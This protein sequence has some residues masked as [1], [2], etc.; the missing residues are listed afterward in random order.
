[1]NNIRMHIPTDTYLKEGLMDQAS[2]MS[3]PYKKAL[4]VTTKS[5]HKGRFGAF[6]KMKT[7]LEKEGLEVAVFD[8]ITRPLTHKS[9]LNGARIAKEEDVDLIVG[10]GGAKVIDAAKVIGR[11]ALENPIYLDAWLSSKYRPPF[12]NTPIDVIAV[13]TTLT[14]KA[15]LNHKIYLYNPKGNRYERLKD[16]SFTPKAA[17]IDPIVFH[18]LDEETLDGTLSDALI[19]LFDLL[20]QDIS[21]LHT[22]VSALALT[23]I[24]R[25]IDRL[26]SDKSQ[27]LSEAAYA[28]MLLSTLYVKKPYFPLHML[29]DSILGYHPDIHYSTFLKKASLHYINHRIL[30]VSGERLEYI[31]DAFLNTPY[32]KETLKESFWALFSELNTSKEKI[33][34]TQ[35]H[36]PEDYL[37]HLKTLFPAFSA[38]KDSAVYTIIDATVQ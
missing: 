12:E 6:E 9:V 1:M 19:T 31:H 25:S 16:A 34:F 10:H 26:K 30:Q 13:P 2:P 11:M 38:L 22:D 32:Y 21:L 3:L 27:A 28:H 14:L 36:Y 7:M 20:T 37:I 29:N 24:V 4:I 17:F 8:E 15:S 35:K 18:T 5:I 33:A 23:H